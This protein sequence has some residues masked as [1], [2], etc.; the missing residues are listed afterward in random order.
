MKFNLHTVRKLGLA[1][2]LFSLVALG[3]GCS[4]SNTPAPAPPPSAAAVTSEADK[5]KVMQDM[6]AFKDKKK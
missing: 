5:Q 2:F 1:G 3:C 6:Q 4:Q